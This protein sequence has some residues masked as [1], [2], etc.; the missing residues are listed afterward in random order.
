M[1][2]E[3]YGSEH[4]AE[5]EDQVA[6]RDL[7]EVAVIEGFV[8]ALCGSHVARCGVCHGGCIDNRWC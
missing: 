8:L 2:K 6:S 1:M 5:I 3:V 4:L 7:V